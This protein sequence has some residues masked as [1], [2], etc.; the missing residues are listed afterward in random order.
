MLCDC[1]VI[2]LCVAISAI[3]QALINIAPRVGSGALIMDTCSVKQ[4][5]IECMERELPRRVEIIGTH[6]MFGPDSVSYQSDSSPLVKGLPLVY[7]PAR[8]NES[9]IERWRSY[10]GQIGLQVITMTPSDHD[11]EAA[12]TQGITHFIGRLLEHLRLRKSSIATL[13][14]Q[15]LLAIIEQTCNDPYQLFLDL[16]RNNGYTAMMRGDLRRALQ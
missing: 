8:A 12:Y 10:F 3:D 9:T 1:D 5:P 7:C 2:F 4:Y 11:K 16:Q 13:G 6:P 14:Y 15:R